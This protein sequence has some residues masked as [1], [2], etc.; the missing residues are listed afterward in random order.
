MTTRGSRYVKHISTLATFATFPS[1]YSEYRLCYYAWRK[2]YLTDIFWL[3]VS[4]SQ[5]SIDQHGSCFGVCR[6]AHFCASAKTIG[7]SIQNVVEHYCSQSSSCRISINET[8]IVKNICFFDSGHYNLFPVGIKRIKPNVDVSVNFEKWLYAKLNDDCVT[9]ESLITFVAVQGT[10]HAKQH[11]SQTWQRRKCGNYPSKGTRLP[12]INEWPC[13]LRR[14]ES[15]FG[16]I[17]SSCNHFVQRRHGRQLR[18]IGGPPISSRRRVTSSWDT[19]SLSNFQ[20]RHR[21]ILVPFKLNLQ[22]L[23]FRAWRLNLFV[24]ITISGDFIMYPTI[25]YRSIL[26]LNICIVFLWIC[27]VT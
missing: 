20:D 21:I 9:A 6:S 12:H 26:L 24:S 11:F 13:A 5:D 22:E 19:R 10:G 8:V 16:R 14:P 17:L 15:I 4:I 25:D 23:D 7:V 3:C 27:L 2:R 1:V 18:R